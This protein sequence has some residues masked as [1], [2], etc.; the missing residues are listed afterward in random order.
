MCLCSGVGVSVLVYTQYTSRILRERV[1]VQ[2]VCSTYVVCGVVVRLSC[3]G[4]DS[5][6][7]TGAGRG[8]TLGTDADCAIEL[9]TEPANQLG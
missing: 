8:G 4:G 1:K 2:L 7:E 6:G 9:V 5:E 3:S